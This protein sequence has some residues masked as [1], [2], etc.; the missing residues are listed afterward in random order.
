MIRI[1]SKLCN[2]CGSCIDI[3]PVKIYSFKFNAIEV[4]ELESCVFCG[5]CIVMCPENAI[6]HDFLK[7]K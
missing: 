3:C 2:H 5:Y 7:Y 4:K 1:N 6:H